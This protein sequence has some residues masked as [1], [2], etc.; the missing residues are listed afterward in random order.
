MYRQAPHVVSGLANT[1]RARFAGL[2]I[3]MLLASGLATP[4]ASAAPPQSRPTFNVVPITITNVVVE[5]S[6]LIAIGSLGSHP[7]TTPLDLTATPNGTDCPI[8]HL[9]LGPIDLNVL[10]LAVNTSAICLDITA[11]PDGGLLGSLLCGIAHLLDQGISLADILAG[12]DEGDLGSLTAGLTRLLN[13]VVFQPLTSSSAVRGARCPILHL[14]LGP[15]DL[16]L[17]GLDI[18]LDNCRG[19]AVTLDVAAVPGAGNLLGNLICALEHLLDGGHASLAAIY[20]ILA[21]I[22]DVIHRLTG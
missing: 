5:N 14:A 3:L 13:R 6:Q 16:N 9:A 20:G 19:G 18:H 7:F 22:A 11:E 17:L 2:L 4:P 12:L 1:I 15:V 21:H 8:L 10:G